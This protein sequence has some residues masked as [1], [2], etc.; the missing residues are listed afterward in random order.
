MNQVSTALVLAVVVAA[1]YY[2][3]AILLPLGLAILLSF[4]LAPL[5]VRLRRLGLGRIPSVLTVVIL[6]TMALSGLTLLVTTQLMSLA[7]DIPRYEWNIRSK[8]R[9]LRDA[10]P[11]GGVLS[12]ATSALQDLNKEIEK[13]AEPEPARVGQKLG[14]GEVDVDKPVPVEIHDRPPTTIETLRDVLGPLVQPVV[15]TGM[16]I[17]FV[18]FMLIE[19]TELRDRLIRL[20]DERDL[21]RATKAIDDAAKRVSRYLLMQLMIAVM[22]GVPYGLGLWLIGIPNPFLWGLLA[23]VLRFIPYLGPVMAAVCPLLLALAVD[24]GWSMVL[25]TAALILALELFTNNVLEPWLYGNVTGLSPVAILVAAVFWTSLWGPVGLFLSVPLT[26]CVVV[27]GRHA[28][29]LAFLDLLLGDKPAL[30][31]PERIYQRLLAGDRHEAIELAETFEGEHGFL[32]LAD[33][34][35]IPVLRH[36]EQDRERRSLDAPTQDRMARVVE[37]IGSYLAES[38]P[39]AYD[40]PGQAENGAQRPRVLC[41]G[42]RHALDLASAAVLGRA[43]ETAEIDARVL[44]N[45][46]LRGGEFLGHTGDRPQLVCITYLSPPS[47]QHSRRIVRRLRAWLPAEVPIIACDWFATERGRFALP[48]R[49]TD[50]SVTTVREAIADVRRSVGLPPIPDEVEA[51]SADTAQLTPAAAGG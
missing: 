35:L 15:S 20:L 45:T 38:D 49:D 44:A 46:D 10:M 21:T 51:A 23:T 3:Q 22:H 7:S 4:A 19:R 32:D 48:E 39:H 37:E 33:E 26:V 40:P 47:P 18:I 8:I 50:R 9:S 25:T 2:G 17:V 34:I 27:L 42:G 24:P 5:V 16:I 28:P 1:L 30:S 29:Q 41:V 11:E 6:V 43:L 14:E 12:R 13:A 31:M 36:A